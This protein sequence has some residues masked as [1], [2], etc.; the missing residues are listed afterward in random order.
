MEHN[1]YE[2]DALSFSR[3]SRLA[4]H[5]TLFKT[6]SKPGRHFDKGS[7]VDILLT[8]GQEAFNKQVYLHKNNFPTGKV[9]LLADT[10]F[11]NY[12]ESSQI[13]ENIKDFANI[14]YC[15]DV[16]D[17]IDFFVK[18]VDKDARIK[19]FDFDEFWNY[20]EMLN[21]QDRKIVL[22]LEEYETCKK[23]VTSL[24]SHKF[25]K[26]YSQLTAGDNEEIF[27][28]LEV[29]WTVLGEDMKCKLDKVIVNHKE[30][31]IQPIDFK[32][33]GDST[34][35]FYKSIRMFNYNYQASIYV[36][37]IKIYFKN[38]LENYTV[39][40]FMFIIETTKFDYIGTPRKFI[41]NEKTLEL[42]KTG[43]TINGKIVKGWHDLILDKIWYDEHGYEDHRDYIENKG[44][45]EIS[46][47]D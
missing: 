3:L 9:L 26:N 15:L 5:P 6:K 36:E 14:A 35:S 42:S 25:T 24:K 43:G 39:L 7:A 18:M 20:L 28:Q 21:M 17:E 44:T 34:I 22:S 31:T 47:Y 32:T 4:T 45:I 29:Y 8:E 40:P 37:G 38:L 12:C 11:K 41:I 19:K 23:I 46:L 33:T 10:I 16:M 2:V 13:T 30:K 27:Y 1:Y